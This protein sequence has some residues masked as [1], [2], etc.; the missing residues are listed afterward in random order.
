MEFPGLNGSRC[1]SLRG[2]EIT[3]LMKTAQLAVTGLGSC[4]IFRIMPLEG[5][6][7]SARTAELFVFTAGQRRSCN[8]LRSA[9]IS[10]G[11]RQ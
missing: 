10:L 9:E 6:L 3:A 1:P 7:I 2:D 5:A 4:Y 8:F 11:S